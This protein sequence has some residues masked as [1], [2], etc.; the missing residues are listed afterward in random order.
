M[1]MYSLHTGLLASRIFPL[2]TNLQ[3]VNVIIAMKGV[4]YNWPIIVSTTL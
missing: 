4:Q 3:S 1:Y 2:K